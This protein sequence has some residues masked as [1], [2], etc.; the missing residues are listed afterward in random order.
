[1]DHL[2]RGC[3]AHVAD[4]AVGLWGLG[5]GNDEYVDAGAAG[6]GSDEDRANVALSISEKVIDGPS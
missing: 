1:M 3:V 5:R 6:R 2:D 4:S